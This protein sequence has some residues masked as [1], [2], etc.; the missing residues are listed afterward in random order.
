VVTDGR[1]KGHSVGGGIEEKKDSRSMGRGMPPPHAGG[2]EGMVRKTL[3]K[4][5]L[6]ECEKWTPVENFNH[7]H[8]AG[9]R[10]EASTIVC[11]D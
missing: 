2:R 10:K 7:A 4:G 5:G 1:V 8:Q 6:T 11:D 3:I 9:K